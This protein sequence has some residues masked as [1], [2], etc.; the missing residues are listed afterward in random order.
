MWHTRLSEEYHIGGWRHVQGKLTGGG[1][2]II[3]GGKREERGREAFMTRMLR[4]PSKGRREKW[5]GEHS[6]TRRPDGAPT[7]GGAK[8]LCEE[9]A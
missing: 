9:D 3:S 5:G 2:S 4:E 7:S 8:E 6:L 1:G